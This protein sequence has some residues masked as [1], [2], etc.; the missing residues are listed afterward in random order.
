MALVQVTITSTGD[1]SNDA[2]VGR[3]LTDELADLWNAKINTVDGT[4]AHD[5]TRRIRNLRLV[6]GEIVEANDQRYE[7]DV[8]AGAK[9]VWEMD[10]RDVELFEILMTNEYRLHSLF[11]HI[12]TSIIGMENWDTMIGVEDLSIEKPWK[13][14]IDPV[15]SPTIKR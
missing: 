7:D 9:L 8:R 2:I 4:S 1:A 5:S 15:M 12:V 10:E 3:T 14:V 11:G 6:G 13:L